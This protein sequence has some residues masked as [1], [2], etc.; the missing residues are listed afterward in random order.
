MAVPTIHVTDS[1]REVI[2]T[3]ARDEGARALRITIGDAFDHEMRFDEPAADDVVIPLGNIAILLDPHS[4]GRAEG[5]SIDYVNRPDGSGFVVENPNIPK[6]RQINAHELELLMTSGSPFLLIDVRTEQERAIAT[7]EGSRLLDESS[8]E[9]LA[10]LDR[11]T[12]LVFQCHHGIRSQAAAE[13]FVHEGFRNGFNHEG[14]IDAWS[15]MV[16]PR[17]PRY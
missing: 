5:M 3:T 9:E 1:A 10:T 11:N 4:A 13:H 12:P 17:V 7:I 15:Q 14:G 8:Y 2:E 6:V 16:D